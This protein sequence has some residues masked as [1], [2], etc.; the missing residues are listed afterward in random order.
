LPDCTQFPTRT[1]AVDLCEDESVLRRCVADVIAD[2]R[3]AGVVEGDQMQAGQITETA[4]AAGTCRDRDGRHVGG[5]N[6][7]IDRYELLC[8]GVRGPLAQV[9]NRIVRRRWLIVEDQ[10]S[11]GADPPV[12]CQQ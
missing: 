6:I 3:H 9:A 1:S 10:V 8:A 12:R 4:S 5:H 7:E 2:H 11:V